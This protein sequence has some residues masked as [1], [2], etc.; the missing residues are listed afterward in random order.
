L[1]IAHVLRLSDAINSQTTVLLQNWSHQ[2]AVDLAAFNMPRS[3][4]QTHRPSSCSL[5]YCELSNAITH[6]VNGHI[7]KAPGILPT[8]TSQWELSRQSHWNASQWLCGVGGSFQ[9][10]PSPLLVRVRI[11]LTVAD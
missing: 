8:E 11:G 10:R 1:T 6:G 4:Y 9:R 7:C 2:C 3:P 5:C